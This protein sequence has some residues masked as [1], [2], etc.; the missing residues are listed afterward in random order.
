MHKQGQDVFTPPVK[1]EMQLAENERS[2]NSGTETSVCEAESPRS[3]KN[4]PTL[5]IGRDQE[6]PDQELHDNLK[7]LY[8][9]LKEKSD[10]EI[11]MSERKSSKDER[12]LDPHPRKIRMNCNQS[13]CADDDDKYK[14]QCNKC[15]KLFHYACTGLP[16]YQICQ[17]MVKGYRMYLCRT[18]TIIP[19]F[20]TESSSLTADR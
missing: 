3:P 1:E 5:P 13:T 8:D 7:A 6:L 16:M 19:K 14:L 20:L 15:D 12:Q 4:T 11:E 18:C 2:G 10:L 9:R 17:F